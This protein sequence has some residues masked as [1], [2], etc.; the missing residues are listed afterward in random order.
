LV[1]QSA[2]SREARDRNNPTSPRQINLPGSIIAQEFHPSEAAGGFSNR[3][4]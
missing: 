1:A 4:A 3:R 2:H